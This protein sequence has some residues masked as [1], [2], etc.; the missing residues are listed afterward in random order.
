MEITGKVIEINL[1]A[2]V[3]KKDGG[4]YPGA[5]ITF[6]DANGKVQEKGFHANAFKYNAALKNGLENLSAG[7]EFT[8]VLEKKD[9]FWNWLSVSKGIASATKE[10]TKSQNNTQQASKAAPSTYATAEERAQTQK[11]I[12]RQSSITNALKLL[13]LNQQ[14]LKGLK[15][16]QTYSTDDVIALA[17]DF[18][19]YVFDYEPTA[20]A[21]SGK[22][23]SGIKDMNDDIPF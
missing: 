9:D 1:N 23:T 14:E 21:D 15:E 8:A 17:S 6:R 10:Q 16:K 18:E 2:Q 19:A 5:T 7:D 11:Y 4:S 3:P 20:L 22:V 12:V 13:E